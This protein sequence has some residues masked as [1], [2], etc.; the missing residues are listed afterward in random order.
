MKYS[1]RINRRYPA[2]FTRAVPQPRNRLESPFFRSSRLFLQFLAPFS[3]W[4]GMET[5]PIGPDERENKTRIAPNT[6]LTIT[7]TAKTMKT[8]HSL[9]GRSSTGF[10][11]SCA[12]DR[13]SAAS[14][15]CRDDARATVRGSERDLDGDRQPR[16][17]T[18]MVTRRRCCPTARCSS[19]AVMATSAF[20]R[21]R[22]STI[23]RA[24]PGRR[25]AASPPHAMFTRRRCCPTARCLSQA[26]MAATATSLASAELYDP[27]SGTWTATGSLN[28]AR[29]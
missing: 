28:T 13:V 11:D 6:R 9:V 4:K 2:G 3:F 18:L 19:Q 23:R 12:A 21:A 27:A 16:H 25:P 14:T 29:D 1:G 10:L 22:N 17:R 5:Y 24:G 20:S 15:H 8:L 26:A 7:H